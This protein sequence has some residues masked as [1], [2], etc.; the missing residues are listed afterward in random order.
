MRPNDLVEKY[1]F[2]P[3]PVC[4]SEPLTKTTHEASAAANGTSP[5][6]RPVHHVSVPENPYFHSKAARTHYAPNIFPPFKFDAGRLEAS[7]RSLYRAMEQLA[8]ALVEI[9]EKVLQMPPRFLTR[10]FCHHQHTSILTLNG[11]PPLSEAV[12]QQAHRQGQCRVAAH[13]DVSLFTLL[14]MD[15]PCLQ[16]GGLQIQCARTGQ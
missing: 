9:F 3:C 16:G 14:L 4:P 11:Y 8:L 7:V 2:G 10:W 13:T 5:A 1:R 12:L 15:K 6:A